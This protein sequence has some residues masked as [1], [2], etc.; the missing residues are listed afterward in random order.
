LNFSRKKIRIDPAP[1]DLAMKAY[2]GRTV[3]VM[4]NLD[5]R[6]LLEIID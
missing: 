4:H 3:T 2:V 1:M 6:H 5:L